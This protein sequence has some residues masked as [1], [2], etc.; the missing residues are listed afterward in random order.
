MSTFIV[1]S[2]LD[3]AITT[4]QPNPGFPRNAFEVEKTEIKG[5]KPSEPLSAHS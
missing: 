4:L 3:H 2:T 5:E 1:G